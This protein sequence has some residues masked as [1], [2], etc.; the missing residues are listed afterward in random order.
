MAGMS[1]SEKGFTLIELLIS[2]TIVGVILVI[3][4]GALRIG[5][6]AWETGERDIEINQR[7]QIVL[8]LLEKQMASI[9][10]DE[11]QKEK[12]DSYYFGGRADFMEFVSSVSLA[13]ENEFGK[14]YVVYRIVSDGSDGLALEVAEQ[15]LAK[16]NPDKTLYEP[17]DAEFYELIS[18]VDDMSFEYL[19]PS[20]ERG[21]VWGNEAMPLKESGLPVA[22]R[23]NLKMIKEKPTLSII[24]RITA[25][26]DSL[27][28]RGGRA[29]R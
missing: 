3:V 6:R 10:W 9:C 14:V 27:L 13:P 20:E 17:D 2:I 15:S 26:Q 12:T 18:G 22:V 8:S 25:Q 19:M 5:V 16:L 29:A 21:N 11:I 24:A 28:Q 1:G 23:F 4:M 7:Q